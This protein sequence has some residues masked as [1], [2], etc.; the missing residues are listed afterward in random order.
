MSNDLISEKWGK[1]LLYLFLSLLVWLVI[2]LAAFIFI[3]GIN[4]GE[5]G[6]EGRISFVVA[7]VISQGLTL[8]GILVARHG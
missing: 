2:W 3:N 8:I 1:T 5:W 7:V 4:I 6:V